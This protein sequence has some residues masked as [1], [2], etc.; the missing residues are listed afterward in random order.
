MQDRKEN[1]EYVFE[2][3]L[4][5]GPSAHLKYERHGLSRVQC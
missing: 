5:T 1:G 3:C 4:P 2:E